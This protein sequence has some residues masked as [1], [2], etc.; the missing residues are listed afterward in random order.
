[1]MR[2]R[3]R[4]LLG[5]AALL[6]G[7]AAYPRVAGVWPALRGYTRNLPA[8]GA[9]FPEWPL[10][11]R[12]TRILIVGPHGDD[13]TLGCAG[14]IRMAL[15]RGAQVRVA[16]LTNGD[17][18]HLAAARAFNKPATAPFL[19]PISP[20]EY[21]QLAR[22]RQRETLRAM[23]LLGL[24]ESQVDFLGYPDRG[25]L[26][27]WETFWEPE[28][29]YTSPYTRADHS[30]YERAFRPHAPYCGRALVEDL[31]T[32]L[33]RFRPQWV[34][35]PHPDDS[36]P[37]HKYGYAFVVTALAQ[38]AEGRRV[39]I[40]AYLVHSPSWPSPPGLFLPLPLA[41]P[42]ALRGPGHRWEVLPLSGPV[43]ERKRQAVLAYTSQTAVLGGLLKSFARANELFERDP[44]S[45]FP[46]RP[47]G[48]ARAKVIE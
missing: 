11:A 3:R 43:R 2:V 1:M 17:G 40:G 27:M 18:F 37:D 47:P 13:E 16:L 42:A 20:A 8:A 12:G 4:R 41:P 25:L 23:A 30:P 45:P 35:T 39:V 32:L 31:C 36:H 6:L 22:L 15:Q 24:P 33:R 5:L 29:P 26:P 34:F 46:A 48:A 28:R 44:P 19:P 14:L 38:V 10:P 9:R 21:L 7:A